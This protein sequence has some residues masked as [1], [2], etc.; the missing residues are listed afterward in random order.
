MRFDCSVIGLILCQLTSTGLPL[1][2]L[3]DF[4]MKFRV[5]WGV[6]SSGPASAV[7]PP[8]LCFLQGR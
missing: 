8:A 4:F 5:F 2:V 3:Y 7:L 1:S 6:N